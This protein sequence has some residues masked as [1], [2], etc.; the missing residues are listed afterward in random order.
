MTRLFPC[1]PLPND[2]HL[3]QKIPTLRSSLARS[4]EQP[5]VPWAQLPKDRSLPVALPL[6][7]SKESIGRLAFCRDVGYADK[8][9][10]VISQQL[11]DQCGVLV[12]LLAQ[13]VKL[14]DGII[15]CL[16]GKMTSLIW[17]V[18][19]LVIEDREIEGKTE[20]DGMSWSKVRLCDFGSVLVCFQ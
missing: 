13:C 11:H 9:Y 20:T 3:S 8:S 14:G 10:Q 5:P 1:Q 19:N 2:T 7:M 16:L 15:K 12:A 17:R 18:E 4:P 6:M